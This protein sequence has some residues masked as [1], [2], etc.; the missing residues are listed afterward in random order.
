MLLLNTITSRKWK[1][2]IINALGYTGG[3]NKIKRKKAITKR[4]GLLAP[5]FVFSNNRFK[6]NN[7]G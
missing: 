5:S 4:K 6:E 3:V 7:I 1:K 2:S